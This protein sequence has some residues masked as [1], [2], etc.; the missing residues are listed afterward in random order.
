[1]EKQKDERASIMVKATPCQRTF[2]KHGIYEA[3]KTTGKD[4]GRGV[5]STPL[6]AILDAATGASEDIG[7]GI[8][9]V[10]ALSERGLI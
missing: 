2:L 7:A 1:M 9:L 4:F 8:V 6:Q 3:E 5:Y 10:N